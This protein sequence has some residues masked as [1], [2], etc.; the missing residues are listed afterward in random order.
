MDTDSLLILLKNTPDLSDQKMEEIYLK[1][2]LKLTDLIEKS[3]DPKC[4]ES[5]LYITKH[6]TVKQCELIHGNL[7]QIL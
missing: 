5:I 1:S 6:S 4:Q 2:G 3:N 7:Q